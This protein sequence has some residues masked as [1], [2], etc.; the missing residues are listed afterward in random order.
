MARET[1]RLRITGAFL[2]L[3]AMI[4]TVPASAN[5]WKA[6][7]IAAAKVRELDT[8]LMVSALRCRT[9]SGDFLAHYNRFV[10]DNRA[11][12]AEDV[13][14]LHAHFMTGGNVNR[15]LD[16]Y[17]NFV[18]KMAN[19]YGAGVDGMRCEDIES[20]VT[21]AESE[22]G[23]FD[24]LVQMA[25]RA[26]IVPV[27]DDAACDVAPQIAPPQI[28]DAGSSSSNQAVSPQTASA[29]VRLPSILSSGA[30]R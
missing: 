2:A 23:S 19:H 5:C 4:T 11:V 26:A 21:A 18:T 1:Q 20:L 7:E 27:L 13:L 29:Q 3:A 9:S 12:L 16:L 8:M 24:Q 15:S 6:E 22:A 30:Q 25:D 17:D 10:V 28:A 14:R